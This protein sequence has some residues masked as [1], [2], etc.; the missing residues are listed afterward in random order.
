MSAPRQM[1]SA[2]ARGCEVTLARN[3]AGLLL[4]LA[5]TEPFTTVFRRRWKHACRA[6]ERVSE[7]DT[8][9]ILHRQNEALLLLQVPADDPLAEKLAPRL[10]TGLFA[11]VSVERAAKIFRLTKAELSAHSAQPSLTLRGE[12]HGRSYSYPAYSTDD[13]LELRES[14]AVQAEP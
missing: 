10:A 9:R 4:L 2:S 12:R 1:F 11:P 8:C 6:V 7:A 14:L 5:G 13:I 3:A